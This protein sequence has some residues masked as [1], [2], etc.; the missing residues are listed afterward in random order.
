MTFETV[1]FLEMKI[2]IFQSFLLLGN[3]GESFTN[4]SQ[5]QLDLFKSITG[6]NATEAHIIWHE[7]EEHIQTNRKRRSVRNNL[8]PKFRLEITDVSFRRQ[9]VLNKTD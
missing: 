5:E 1:P 7:A 9:F 8:Q 3:C 4:K 2:L 6:I